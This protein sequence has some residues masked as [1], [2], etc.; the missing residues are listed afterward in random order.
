MPGVDPAFRS[1]PRTRRRE[2]EGAHQ[3]V[4]LRP[5]PR[6]NGNEQPRVRMHPLQPGKGGKARLRD[7]AS[8]TTA[9]HSSRALRTATALSRRLH[10]PKLRRK[11]A[12]NRT[13]RTSGRKFIHH[14]K[15]CEV[16]TGLKVTN[17][18]VVMKKHQGGSREL[19]IPK[20]NVTR[21]WGSFAKKR[22]EKSG[23][24]RPMWRYS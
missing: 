23:A 15:Y 14:V 5:E 1:F 7:G 22:V 6:R 2:C 11:L 3:P 18:I 9:Q 24:G 12:N 19:S 16:M 21:P 17:A 13:G 20:R 10:S 4:A 8:R